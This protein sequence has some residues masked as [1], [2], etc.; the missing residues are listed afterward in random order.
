MDGELLDDIL[1]DIRRGSPVDSF[2][3]YNSGDAISP[4]DTPDLAVSLSGSVDTGFT[5]GTCIGDLCGSPEVWSRVVLSRAFAARNAAF[6]DRLAN[7]G[8]LFKLFDEQRV[9]GTLLSQP[10]FAWAQL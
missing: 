9:H 1:D 8:S 5:A 4:I 3:G 7:R 6:D 2:I 10:V